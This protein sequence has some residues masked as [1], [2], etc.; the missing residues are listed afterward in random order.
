M[1]KNINFS[2]KRIAAI[3]WL[4]DSKYNRVPA[5]QAQFAEKI[6]IRT[7]TI[8]RWKREPDFKAAITARARELA[9]ESL[10]EVYAA[11]AREAIA[12]SFQ[13]IKLLM[14]MTG[15]YTPTEKTDHS[16]EISIR[17]EYGDINDNATQATPGTD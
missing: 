4:A 17:V 11:L 14:E 13:H 5:T 8:S 15:E 2:A 12:G 7:E 1:S 16:G 9:G 3:E 6:G 10:P